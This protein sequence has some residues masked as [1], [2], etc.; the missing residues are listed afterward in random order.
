MDDIPLIVQDRKCNDDGHPVYDNGHVEGE[1]PGL[2]DNP[3]GM[4][5][6]TILV[7]GTRAPFLELPAKLVRLRVLNASNARRY[8]LGG[9]LWCPPQ[10]S[11]RRF[12]SI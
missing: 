1:A 3:P 10:A 9:S 2:L 8:N 6:D 4:L 12:W 7:N 5:G 11:E